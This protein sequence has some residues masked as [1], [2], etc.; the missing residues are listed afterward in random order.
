MKTKFITKKRIMSIFAI[1]IIVALTALICIP[2]LTVLADYSGQDDS[3]TRE[4]S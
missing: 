1:C 2:T 4:Q 3:L